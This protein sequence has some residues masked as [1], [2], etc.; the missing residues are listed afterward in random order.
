MRQTKSCNRFDEPQINVRRAQ[1]GFV[2]ADEIRA[3]SRR[4]CR[5]AVCLHFDFM[6]I[7]FGRVRFVRCTKC[8]ASKCRLESPAEAAEDAMKALVCLH[9]AELCT[10]GQRTK[11]NEL[12]PKSCESVRDREEKS[13]ERQWQL[14]QRASAGAKC[15]CFLFGPIRIIIE[16]IAALTT[17]MTMSQLSQ[18]LFDCRFALS[19]AARPLAL[20][21]ALPMRIDRATNAPNSI[22]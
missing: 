20:S 12:R 9:V 5:V 7:Q 22:E 3:A 4:W 10:S 2:S 6:I 21:V 14:G 15:S 18:F 8:G 17:P 19:S 11:G 13:S 1:F 16:H